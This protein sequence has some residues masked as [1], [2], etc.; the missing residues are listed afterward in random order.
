M[1]KEEAQSITIFMKLVGQDKTIQ[2]CGKDDAL[3]R[4]IIHKQYGMPVL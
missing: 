3:L 4:E 2:W 1:R